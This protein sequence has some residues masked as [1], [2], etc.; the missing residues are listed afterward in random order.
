MKAPVRLV[1]VETGEVQKKEVFLSDIPL[2]TNSGTF[3]VNGTE[4]VIVSQFIRSPGIYFREKT[5]NIPGFQ[6]YLASIIPSKGA[7]LEIEV[8]SKQLFYAHLNKV[9]KVPLTLFLSA[10]GYDEKSFFDLVKEKDLFEPTI[11]KFPFTNEDDAL[12]ERTKASF[13]RPCYFGG[14]KALL[15]LCF[16]MKKNMIYLMLVDIKLISGF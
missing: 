11:T 4:R 5:P 15:I 7:W 12:I 6:D 3:L 14:A 2:M 13:W 16:L 10:L 8:D 9:K 1:S